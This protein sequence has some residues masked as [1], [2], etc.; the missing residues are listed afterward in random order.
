MQKPRGQAPRLAVGFRC[1]SCSKHQIV[2]ERIRPETGATPQ[3]SRENLAANFNCHQLKLTTG[4]E[5]QIVEIPE[6]LSKG[7]LKISKPF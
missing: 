6:R 2:K 4:W 1:H 3:G 7:V 5:S